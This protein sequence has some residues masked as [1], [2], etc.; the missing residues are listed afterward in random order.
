MKP[1]NLARTLSRIGH[2]RAVTIGALTG[3]ALLCFAPISFAEPAPTRDSKSASLTILT[4]PADAHI[5]MIGASHVRGTSP[6]DMPTLLA[7]RYSLTLSALGRSNSQGV[8]FIP[9]RGGRPYLLSEPPGLSGGLLLRS[10]NIPGVPD[11]S[12]GHVERGSALA[13]AAGGGI[14]ATIRANIF[15]LEDADELDPGSQAD[16]QD[17]KYQRNVW[18]AYTGGVW[19]MSA[20]D[21]IIRARVDLLESTPTRITV[22]A[23]PVTRGSVILRSLVI[24]GAGQ[25]F[26]NQRGRSFWWLSATLASGAGYVIAVDSHHR[27]QTDLDQAQA[28]LAAA[29]PGDVPAREAEV[30]HFEESENNSAKVVRNWGYLALFVYASNLIDAAVLM[31]L[32]NPASSAP[33]K[34]SLS[35]PVSQDG[36]G[37]AISRR[38]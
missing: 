2:G 11:I 34:V 33:P 8:I 21:Y 14:A 23:P 31:P 22:G 13:I 15:Y 38:F 20:L 9:P 32:H 17:W 5:V 35:V 36:V 30:A 16:A 7:G 3:A 27:I 24:P 29:S 25:E 1:Q 4:S 37:L 10:L 28:N 19:I 18:A 6:L 26:A 12:A